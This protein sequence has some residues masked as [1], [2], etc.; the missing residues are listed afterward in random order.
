M[1]AIFIAADVSNKFAIVVKIHDIILHIMLAIAIVLKV[2]LL[3][4]LIPKLLSSVLHKGFNVR[5]CPFVK[6]RNRVAG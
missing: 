2:V 6:F 3:L 5:R 4:L 1:I